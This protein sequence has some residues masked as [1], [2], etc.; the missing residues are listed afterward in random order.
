MRWRASSTTSWPIPEMLYELGEALLSGSDPGV[1]RMGTAV[2]HQIPRPEHQIP[3]NMGDFHRSAGIKSDVVELGIGFPDEFRCSRRAKGWHPRY[4]DLY[5]TEVQIPQCRPK[6]VGVVAADQGRAQRP[7]RHGVPVS[8][9]FAGWQILRVKSSLDHVF[10]LGPRRRS[11]SEDEEEAPFMSRLRVLTW[12]F[13]VR[14]PL[15]RAFI[16]STCA[17]VS[18][19]Q[20]HIASG[21]WACSHVV[22]TRGGVVPG[23][24]SA[25]SGRRV[26]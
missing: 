16:A 22:P 5:R 14:C 6:V 23:L 11:A 25:E 8:K 20:S 17:S 24:L 9:T 10:T 21:N 26:W 3:A 4:R 12:C 2:D 18:H 19:V 7:V 1:E 13:V 15:T